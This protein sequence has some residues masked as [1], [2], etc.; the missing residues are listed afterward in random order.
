MQK[1]YNTVY[2]IENCVQLML[3]TPDPQCP[4]LRSEGTLFMCVFVYVISI[5]YCL[6]PKIGSMTP[7]ARMVAPTL[8]A[9]NVSE[10]GYRKK[11][12]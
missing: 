6:E 12:R 4:D 2:W 11:L 7:T 5:L 3:M 9:H 1:R 8:P 10:K